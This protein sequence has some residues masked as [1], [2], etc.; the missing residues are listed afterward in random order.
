MFSK[1]DAKRIR[2]EFWTSFGQEYP[3]KWLLYNTKVKEISLK[4]TFTTKLAQVS[5]DIDADDALIQEY[6]YEK[7]WS[8]EQILKTEFI[9][10]IILDPKYEVTAGKFVSRAYI[11]LNNVSIHNKKT[12]QE[13]YHFLY[14]NMTQLEL[15]FYE[16]EDFIKG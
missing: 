8:L 10:N 2:Q 13:V 11:Q 12:W 4:F 14:D 7:I 9:P 3:R 6:Y 16:Y 1:E 15:F 5:I